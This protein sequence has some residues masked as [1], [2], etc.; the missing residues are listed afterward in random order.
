VIFVASATPEQHS[1]AEA[2][3]EPAEHSQDRLEAVHAPG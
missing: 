2:E 1:E 3:H